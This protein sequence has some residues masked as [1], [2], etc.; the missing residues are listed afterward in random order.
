MV[1]NF[2][3]IKKADEVIA[4]AKKGEN[5]SKQEKILL[6]EISEFQKTFEDLKLTPGA[7]GIKLGDKQMNLSEFG[8]TFKEQQKFKQLSK[9]MDSLKDV[10]NKKE[11]DNINKILEL[12]E[13]NAKFT[14]DGLDSLQEGY[15]NAKNLEINSGVYNKGEEIYKASY[16]SYEQICQS[17]RTCRQSRR[18]KIHIK[19]EKTIL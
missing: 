13:R 11:F 1:K 5:L 4:R 8:L 10:A 6:E 19:G 12:G 14:T 17:Q 15:K 16:E 3:I 7:G 18:W 9:S 2:L